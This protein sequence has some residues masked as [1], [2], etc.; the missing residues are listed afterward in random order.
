MID[1]SN[2]ADGQ[3]G[4]LSYGYHGA[5]TG[6]AGHLLNDIG[7]GTNR[8]VCASL[9]PNF[10][11]AVWQYHTCPTGISLPTGLF[12]SWENFCAYYNR[13]PPRIRN[14]LSN[15][16]IDLRGDAK[17]IINVYG[18]LGK[19][20]GQSSVSITTVFRT[21]I[22]RKFIFLREISVIVCGFNK[23]NTWSTW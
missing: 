23:Y 6:V 1:A 9:G 11:Q 18:R 7:D 4:K 10:L 21:L 14:C 13:A 8:V 3:N 5:D 17:G 20:C 22:I 16:A 2:F 12:R 19:C 15:T